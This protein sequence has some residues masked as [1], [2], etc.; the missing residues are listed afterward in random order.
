MTTYYSFLLPIVFELNGSRYL[1]WGY[2]EEDKGI[3]GFSATQ[4]SDQAWTN[5][6]FFDD[7]KLVEEFKRH[8][9]EGRVR[10]KK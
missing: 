3:V 10:K 4:A 2:T 5:P 6:T 7:K 1:V 8:L 9:P